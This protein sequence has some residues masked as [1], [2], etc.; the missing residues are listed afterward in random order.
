[1]PLALLTA[2]AC[3]L[4]APAD[5]G[6]PGL[7]PVRAYGAV[8][9]GA[10]DD[11]EA[12]RRAAQAAAEV[13][14]TVVV[15]PVRG[16]A[17]YVLSG[18]VDLPPGVSLVGAPAGMPFF[19]WEGV[20]RE[21]QA[22]PVI[23]ARPREEDYRGERRRPL[24]ELGGGNTVRGLY[25][26]Y[27]EQPWPSDE[28]VQAPDSPYHYD[29][30]EAFRERFVA[31]HARPYGPTFHGRH[32]ASVTIEDITCAGYWDFCVFDLAGKLF[33]ERCYLYG[34]K[35]AFAI[36]HGPDTVRLRGIHLVPN[37]STAISWQHSWLQAAIAW[38]EDN[39]AF[40]FAAVDGYSVSDVVVF[41]VHTGFRLGADEAAPF[42]N[43][44]SGSRTA[45]EWG[46]G[47][48]GSIENV[49]LDNVCVGFD[50][51][52]GTILPNQL[53]NVMVHVSLPAARPIETTGGTV[54]RQAAILV[55]PGFAGATLQ[56]GNLLLSSFAP[57]RVCQGAQ[58]V[59][60]ANGRA[61]LLTCPGLDEPRD[62]ADRRATH[63]MI[64]NLSVTNIDT[65][66]LLG[67]GPGNRATV[68]A[69]TFVHNGVAKEWG[70]AAE[71]R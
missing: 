56:I 48:W 15:E 46:R 30:F 64:G 36:E 9:D 42:V 10:A 8:G 67:T 49:K 6:W 17:G 41:L 22:G 26:L 53:Q 63:V 65:A 14:G 20:P 44:V 55:E 59:G 19:V 51:L 3:Q 35:R 43:P 40:D 23:L 21:R 52:T 57:T 18:T 16:G 71:G 50:C 69:T 4:A 47:P 32:A 37:V 24:F 29:S 38:Q 70:A 62:Y 27:D 12:F 66:H 13:G 1:M 31:E 11:T 2:L 68:H 25:V 45:L 58:M 7:F 34:Y 5:T 28:E 60:Q 61:F 33:V 54:A 39:I